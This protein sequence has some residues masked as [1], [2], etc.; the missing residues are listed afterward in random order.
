MVQ[1]NSKDAIIHTACFPVATFL[2]VQLTNYIT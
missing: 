1:L 2:S